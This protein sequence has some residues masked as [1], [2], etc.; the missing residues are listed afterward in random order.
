[1]VVHAGT[2]QG[3]R[4]K[5][6]EAGSSPHTRAVPAF[7]LVIKA[8]DMPAQTEGAADP[9]IRPSGM[10]YASVKVPPTPRADSKKTISD[11]LDVLDL[12]DED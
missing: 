9:K 5:T 4:P 7:K 10:N 12:I 8:D 1:M 3:R 2:E 11:R 6:H